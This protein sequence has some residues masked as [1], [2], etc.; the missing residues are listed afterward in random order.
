MKFAGPFCLFLLVFA[1]S[2]FGVSRMVTHNPYPEICHFVVERIYI[3]PEKLK[4]WLALC[5]SRKK[6]VKPWS[7]KDLV[8]RDVNNILDLLK[9]SHLNLLAPHDVN[10]YWRGQVYETGVETTFI[11]G[12]LVVTQVHPGS[13]A[14]DIGFK[15]F[16]IIDSIAGEAPSEESALTSPG[17]WKV[18]RGAKTFDVPVRV[19]DFQKNES[20]RVES[21]SDGITVIRVPSFRASFFARQRWVKEI[22][23]AESAK[24]LILDLRGNVG[25]N[26]FAGVSLLSSFICEEK[27]VGSLVRPRFAKLPIA[28]LPATLD[29]SL[30]VAELKK[31]SR[32]N[33][34]TSPQFAGKVCLPKPRAILVDAN[35]SSVAEMVAL[36]LQESLQVPVMGSP[37]AGRLLVG[38]W[39]DWSELGEG[40]ELSVPEALF[41]SS[42][43]AEIEGRGVRPDRELFYRLK[44]VQSGKDSWLNQVF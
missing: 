12:S 14:E 22:K 26:F 17:M 1:L 32:L 11:E 35:T 31:S 18:R 39:Y 36:V 30:Q 6:L 37:T 43:N 7:S 16:D 4:N 29:D 19:G 24:N 8:L 23:K 9:V 20:L 41:V 38:L 3:E 25:G 2:F 13:P 42:K 44:D 27:I 33:L 10:K 34:K 21:P 28:D 40:V 5:Q 15:V